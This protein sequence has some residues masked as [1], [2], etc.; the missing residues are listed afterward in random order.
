VTAASQTEPSV[1]DDVSVVICAYT[2]R[3]WDALLVAIASLRRQT[4]PVAEIILVVDHNPSLLERARAEIDDVVILENVHDAGLSGG[5]NTGIEAATKPIVAFLDDDAEA[6]PEWVERLVEL[7]ERDG[8]LGAGGRARPRWLAERPRWLPEEFF[9]VVGCTY[10]GVPE[11]VSPVRNLFGSCFCVRRDIL[12]QVG[13][14]RRELGRTGANGMGCEETDLC[15]RAN[16]AWPGHFFLYDPDAI[17]H[18]EVPADRCTWRYFRTR[19][20]GE[21]LS[22]ATLVSL[23]GSESALATERAYVA[24]TLTAAVGRRLAATVRGEREQLLQAGAIVAGL[25][26]TAA[27]YAR[28]RLRR[29]LSRSGAVQPPARTP[30]AR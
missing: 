26:F 23:V 29:R 22:K 18:H 9:W 7:S 15:I 19:C 4:Y 25:G 28:G 17:I 24:R 6:E 2:E 12:V 30:V 13:G 10:K 1:Q 16:Q 3:R 21:G 20:Y 8:S 5:R 11:E 14:F 27:G